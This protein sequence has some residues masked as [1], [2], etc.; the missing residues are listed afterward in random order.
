M[1]TEI[2]YCINKKKI[3]KVLHSKSISVSFFLNDQ[4]YYVFFLVVLCLV[5][6][7]IKMKAAKI[8]KKRNNVTHLHQIKTKI[9]S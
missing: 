7:K 2:L 4:I 5:K 3:I 9:I 6:T 1:C 8:N